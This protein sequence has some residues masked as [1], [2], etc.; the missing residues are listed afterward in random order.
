MAARLD[1][2]GNNPYEKAAKKAESKW[3]RYIK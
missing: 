3:K 2:Y 1:G